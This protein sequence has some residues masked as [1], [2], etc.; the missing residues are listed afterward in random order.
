MTAE[1]TKQEL[2]LC[3]IGLALLSLGLLMLGLRKEN[4]HE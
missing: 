2:A 3:V 4:A 1:M